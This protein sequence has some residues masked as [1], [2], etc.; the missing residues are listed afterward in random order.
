LRLLGK[1]T[2]DRDLM[3]GVKATDTLKQSIHNPQKKNEDT[4]WIEISG[5]KRIRN[6]PETTMSR[7]Q[8]K[9]KH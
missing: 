4:S 5:K 8:P 2:P 7:K 3:N 9:N 6:S 1:S